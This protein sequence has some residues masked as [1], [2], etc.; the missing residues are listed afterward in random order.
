MDWIANFILNLKFYFDRSPIPESPFL[1][2]EEWSL[3]WGGRGMI[4]PFLYKFFLRPKYALITSTPPPSTTLLLIPVT[5][6][7]G[8]QPKGPGS[9]SA[10]DLER[11]LQWGLPVQGR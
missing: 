10:M 7:E 5:G 1:Y 11:D 6:W 2:V 8:D 9:K 4:N 3:H